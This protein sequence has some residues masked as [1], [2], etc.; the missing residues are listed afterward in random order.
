MKRQA[1]VCSKMTASLSWK[2]LQ[3]LYVTTPSSYTELEK[4]T[5]DVHDPGGLPSG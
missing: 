2:G 4:L 3:K 5:M 1:S